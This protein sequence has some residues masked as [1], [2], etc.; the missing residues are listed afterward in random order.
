MED[1]PF[2][3]DLGAVFG[4]GGDLGLEP[5]R[6]QGPAQRQEGM[7]VAERPG[8]GENNADGDSSE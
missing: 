4:R 8:G 1:Q 2:G 5:G 3:L 6:L 7:Q